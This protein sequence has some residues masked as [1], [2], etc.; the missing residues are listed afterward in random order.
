[1]QGSGLNQMRGIIPRSIEKVMEAC[2]HLSTQGWEYHLQVSFLE[3]Y[4][5]TIRD[6]LLKPSK[7]EPL[8]LHIKQKS[9]NSKLLY[10]SDL[11]MVDVST[12]DQ[13]D[14]LMERASRQRSVGST[15]M[16]AQSSRSHSVFTLYIT[17]EFLLCIK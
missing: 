1:M 9:V 16:N 5:E 6:L 12:I 11:T 15:D 17:G 14:G 13:I 7:N 10:V 8:K 2:A 3:I 4:N